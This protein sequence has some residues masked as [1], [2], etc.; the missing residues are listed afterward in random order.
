MVPAP[1]AQQHEYRTR[2]CALE[3]HSA[4]SSALI[5]CISMPSTVHA[6]PVEHVPQILGGQR[7]LAHQQRGKLRGDQ[8]GLLA[9]IGRR[10]GDSVI[11]LDVHETRR[12]PVRAD[13]LGGRNSGPSPEKC[14]RC[15]PADQPLLQNAPGN[16]SCRLLHAANGCDLQ[17]SPL[18]RCDGL[19]SFLE[20]SNCWLMRLSAKSRLRAVSPA[21]RLA[22]WRYPRPAG[23]LRLVNAGLRSAH[24]G[25][26]VPI[27]CL[28][29]PGCSDRRTGE[30]RVRQQLLVHREP[31]R[32]AAL[33]IAACSPVASR[34]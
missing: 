32:L 6:V 12:H 33:R 14:G 17:P 20:L 27:S 10:P 24:C 23:R 25:T 30:V 31:P 1:A 22:Q 21:A 2:K 13:P 34:T 29:T 8:I 3:V 15:R 11:G 5:A 4:Q 19:L 7:I 28:V 9:V 16:P 26:V 18:S